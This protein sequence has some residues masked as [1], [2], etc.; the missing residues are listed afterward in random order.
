MYLRREVRH[1]FYLVDFDVKLHTPKFLICEKSG[2]FVLEKNVSKVSYLVSINNNFNNVVLECDR[3]FAIW[4]R[5]NL[6]QS[7]RIL[8]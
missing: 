2:G 1:Y 4:V 6:Y 5:R 7:H 3:L 8:I